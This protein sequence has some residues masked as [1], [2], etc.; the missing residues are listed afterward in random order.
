M[1]PMTIS[2]YE[3]LRTARRS[4]LGFEDYGFRVWSGEPTEAQVARVTAPPSHAEVLRALGPVACREVCRGG[5]V[6]LM[7]D[8]W[9]N[10]GGCCGCAGVHTVGYR[11]AYASALGVGGVGE[12]A[13]A[14]RRAREQFEACRAV[15]IFVWRAA[16][17]DAHAALYRS[18]AGFDALARFGHQVAEIAKIGDAISAFV[19]G[20]IAAW[21]TVVKGRWYRVEGKRGKAKIHHGIEGECVWIGE[22]SYVQERPANWRGNWRGRT[23]TTLRAGI[24][25]LGSLDGAKPIYVPA[26]CLA[27]INAPAEGAARTEK[28]ARAK[29]ERGVRPNYYGRT[30]RKADVGCVVAG[31]HRGTVGQ[32]F[33]S[34]I[35][36]V[37]GEDGRVGVKISKDAEPMWI[38]A[39]DVVGPAARYAEF[40]KFEIERHLDGEPGAKATRLDALLAGAYANAEALADA[41]FDAESEE[42]AAITKQI[43]AA[44]GG[45]VA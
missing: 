16:Q 44:L 12:R 7:S 42:W 1:L 13:D 29:A 9:G 8:D 3:T 11:L 15:G 4:L 2:E 41:G 39:R 17:S 5:T 37:L 45:S 31:P 22:S 30:G 24:L 43:E 20:A 21:N 14:A 10:C 38:G 26:S 33:W 28:R 35:F 36:D 6:Q 27:P 18:V 34:K 32:V 25:P 23:S 40:A 19:Q